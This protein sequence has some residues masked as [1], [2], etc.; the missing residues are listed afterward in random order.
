M[1]TPAR[2]AM[3]AIVG[4][5]TRHPLSLSRTFVSHKTLPAVARPGSGAPGT[6]GPGVRA[7]TGGGAPVA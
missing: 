7:R 6:T 1:E 2:R 3:S 4:R 5:F